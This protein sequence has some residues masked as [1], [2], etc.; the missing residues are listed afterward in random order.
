M[1]I[2]TSIPDY[3]KYLLLTDVRYRYASRH[4]KVAF[5]IDKNTPSTNS[6]INRVAHF[7]LGTLLLIPL[8]GDIIAIV[9]KILGKQNTKSVPPPN[10]LP[11]KKHSQKPNHSTPAKSPAK[12]SQG[13]KNIE[14][15]K[16][17]RDELNRSLAKN[18]Y[19]QANSPDSYGGDF[20]ESIK[21]SI[22]NLPLEEKTQEITDKPCWKYFNPNERILFSKDA[23]FSNYP[24]LMFSILTKNYYL[25]KKLLEH[26]Q[27]NINDTAVHNDI[28]SSSALHLAV[29]LGEE[30]KQYV[31]DLINK[32]ADP[33]IQNGE[34]KTPWDLSQ[35][36]LLSENLHPELCEWSKKNGQDKNGNSKLQQVIEN[37][38]CLDIDIC[39]TEGIFDVCLD[40]QNNNGDTALHLAIRRG[41]I[42]VVKKLIEKECGLNIFNKSGNTVLDEVLCQL[43]KPESIYLDSPTWFEYDIKEILRIILLEKGCNPTFRVNEQKAVSRFQNIFSILGLDALAKYPN[44]RGQ[45]EYRIYQNAN[46]IRTVFGTNTAKYGVASGNFQIPIFTLLQDACHSFLKECKS[47]SKNERTLSI[48]QKSDR[49]IN[50]SNELL[51]LP[52]FGVDKAVQE[53]DENLPILIP[54]GWKGHAIS[55]I[56][57]KKEQLLFVMNKGDNLPDQRSGIRVYKGPNFRLEKLVEQ[58]KAHRDNFKSAKAFYDHISLEGKFIGNI[59]TKSQKRGD[60]T[61]SSCACFGLEGVLALI[62]A[63]KDNADFK[64]ENIISTLSD[65]LRDIKSTIKDFKHHTRKFVLNRDIDF[66]RDHAETLTIKPNTETLR[67]VHFKLKDKL[68]KYS[69]GQKYKKYKELFDILLFNGVK[70]IISVY[71]G[72]EHIYQLYGVKSNDE[73]C[74]FKRALD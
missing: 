41:K 43:W 37:S 8:L 50:F 33:L 22:K 53:A 57:Y 21:I 1:Q 67:Y 66:Y 60:C 68:K 44:L 35:T 62:K 7:S 16:K 32:G 55:V 18:P 59:E 70:G 15:V 30:G 17:G 38:N 61:W 39:F 11:I 64:E 28:G 4:F 3:S 9:E 10:S 24:I 13:E 58:N 14:K 26:E 19:F 47:N 46:N 42:A 69:E 5:N 23:Y 40:H 2:N 52:K 74:K 20:N 65:S 48:L 25:F 29:E 49:V 27:I 71:Y 45:N 31:Q 56:Y 73:Q 12:Q 51:N 72:E 34:G 63:I 6:L 36:L 54:T